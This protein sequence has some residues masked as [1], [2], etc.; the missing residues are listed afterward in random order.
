M[1][2]DDTA[3]LTCQGWQEMAAAN[4]PTAGDS[5]WVSEREESVGWFSKL[6]A[7]LGLDIGGDPTHTWRSLRVMDGE[8]IHLDP[9]PSGGKTYKR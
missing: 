9:W 3:R 2:P 8:K 5:C 4:L 7:K 6:V 1:Y